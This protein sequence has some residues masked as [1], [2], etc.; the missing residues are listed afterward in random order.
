[1]LALVVFANLASQAQQPASPGSEE[2][3][4]RSAWRASM[5]QIPLPDKGCFTASYPVTRWQKVTCTTAPPYPLVPP[6]G[7]A[8]S[9]T[10]GG[11]SSDYVGLVSGLLSQAEG[12]FPSSNAGSSNAYS[13][14][15]N[16]G[17][18]ATP[19]CSGAAIP[20]NCAGLQQFLFE[21]SGSAYMQYW[22]INW[23]TGCP[24]G[25]DKYVPPSDPSEIDCYKNS[26]AASTG[27]QPITELFDMA[28]IGKASGGTDTVLLDYEGGTISAVGADSV[29]DLEQ[30]WSQA[31]FN[32]FGSGNGNEVNIN[33]D[34]S[35]V[36]Q[37]TLNNG[38]TSTPTVQDASFTGETNNLS[39]LG[40]AC[41]YGGATPMIQFMESNDSRANASCGA[42]GIETNI[43]QI[44][45]DSAVWSRYP[46]TGPP[47]YVNW[48]IT[49]F[50]GTP[51]AEITYNI[52]YCND[53][54][55][56]PGSQPS[57]GSFNF[58][59]TGNVQ[60]SCNYSGSMYATAPGYVPS[61]TV[62]MSF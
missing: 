33:A 36:V 8:K 10:V 47:T 45:S 6:K 18:F 28:L 20:L 40:A 26:S 50:D 3:A 46:A 51:G 1:M 30:G 59:L 12:S 35:I 41:T 14:Q 34:A 37:L 23:G 56:L 52:K 15:L 25:W 2:S 13:L 4:R 48:L 21:S 44:P 32:I 11:T 31:E 62:S 57:G 53:E 9:N 38:T 43:T 27:S 16:T 49:V 19:A 24:S 39:L 5:K 61:G 55:A 17:F 29:L 42:S 54:Y 7:H 22:L 58:R 60:M